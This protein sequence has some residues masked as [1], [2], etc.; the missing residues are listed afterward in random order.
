MK[1]TIKHWLFVQ[2]STMKNTIK[3]WLFVQISTIRINS[4]NLKKRIG[5]LFYP[6]KNRMSKQSRLNRKVA[7]IINNF[8]MKGDELSSGFPSNYIQMTKVIVK[9]KKAEVNITVE[10]SRPGLL[11]GKAGRTIDAVNKRL[12][13][14]FNK[15]VNIHIKESYLF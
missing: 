13:D 9:E 4:L 8:F 11:I 3:H 1:N 6:E 7:N 2:R 15:K 12:A 14:Y 10:L 5:Y